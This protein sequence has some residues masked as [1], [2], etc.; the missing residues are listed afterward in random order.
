ML[1]PLLNSKQ[2]WLTT[3]RHFSGFSCAGRTDANK[4]W[5]DRFYVLFDLAQPPQKTDWVKNSAEW[6]WWTVN[7]YSNELLDELALLRHVV[8]NLVFWQRVNM[9]W[10][11]SP[12][13]GMLIRTNCIQSKSLLSGQPSRTPPWGSIL[14][15]CW[16]LLIQ[17]YE[18]TSS[19]MRELKWQ[20]GH[21]D[22][23][24]CRGQAV[25]TTSCMMVIR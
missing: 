10:N 17:S 12:F 25:S 2:H 16:G 8:E 9:C 19:N 24:A 22:A 7:S 21:M 3:A 15:G 1:Y 6:I 11:G 20:E 18:N 14:S 23:W 5:H 13:C 4:V